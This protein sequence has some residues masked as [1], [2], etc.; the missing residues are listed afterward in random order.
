M[1]AYQ[2][3]Y[4]NIYA[5]PTDAFEARYATGIETLL[6]TT[7]TRSQIYDQGLL[8]QRPAVQQHAAGPGVRSPLHRRPTPADLAFV[9]A[10]GF[11]TENLVTNTY[12]GAYLP[13][14]AGTA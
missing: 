9:F 5:A 10:Q 8:P 11:G 2:R 6:P 13:G 3:I 14:L 7:V 1:T 4:G 12:R